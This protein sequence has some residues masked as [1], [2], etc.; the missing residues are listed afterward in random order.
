[1]DTTMSDVIN[2]YERDRYAQ[3]CGMGHRY[4]TDSR[5]PRCP[6]CATVFAD[7]EEEQAAFR[8]TDRIVLWLAQSAIIIA[9]LLAVGWAFGSS[10]EPQADYQAREI[11]RVREAR[12]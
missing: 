9:V 1:M 3:I 8:R 6:T 5:E 12:R 7:I 2:A 11:E 4:E 10:L